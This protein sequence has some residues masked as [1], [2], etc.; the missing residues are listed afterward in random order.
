MSFRT[1]DLVTGPW[2]EHNIKRVTK[3]SDVKG[4]N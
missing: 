4:G 3:K 2:T 1:V